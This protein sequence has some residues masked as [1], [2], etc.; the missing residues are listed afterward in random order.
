MAYNGTIVAD[1]F[2]SLFNNLSVLSVNGISYA[3]SLIQNESLVTR[4]RNTLAS[5][6]A[7]HAEGYFTVASGAYQHVQGTYNIS[8]G[9]IYNS[10]EIVNTIA[11]LT[12]YQK[13]IVFDPVF[14]DTNLI[15][16]S[17]PYS[18][19]SLLASET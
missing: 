4:G 11:R 5:G 18:L 10:K 17:S 9:V 6:Q 7:A 15:T 12:H 19:I 3:I 1:T 13:E 2:L 16:G 14:D 8:S